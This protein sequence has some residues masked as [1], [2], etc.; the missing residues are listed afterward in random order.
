[1]SSTYSFLSSFISDK[2]DESKIP[3]FTTILIV[4]YLYVVIMILLNIHLSI[5]FCRNGKTF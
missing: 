4:R 1:M 3:S 5:L 2:I